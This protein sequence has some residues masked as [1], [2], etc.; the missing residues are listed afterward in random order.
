MCV[1][2]E[3]LCK[4]ACTVCEGRTVEILM[5]QHVA[6]GSFSASGD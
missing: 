6:E 2:N 4:C 5:L 1:G 3:T